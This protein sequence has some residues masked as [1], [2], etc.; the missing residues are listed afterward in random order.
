M[1]D[2]PIRRALLAVE[3]RVRRWNPWLLTTGMVWLLAL[4]LWTVAVP[5]R[6]S[7]LL[8][9]VNGQNRAGK[10]QAEENSN[11]PAAEIPPTAAYLK[12][13]LDNLGDPR[14]TEQQLQSLFAIARGLSLELP[15]GKYRMACEAGAS[16]CKYQIEL[17][18]KG[19]YVRVRSFLEDL[20]MV[21]PFASLDDLS[22][23]RETAS[24]DEIEVRLAMTLFT[25]NTSPAVVGPT[26]AKP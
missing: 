25:R 23:R 7:E 9:M 2:L 22:F 5:A 1:I 19:S 4:G 26:G 3:L 16:F 6:Q 14:Y 24:D 11:A 21:I 13:F 10:A 17:P 12:I 8:G 20:L 18:I 15:Q